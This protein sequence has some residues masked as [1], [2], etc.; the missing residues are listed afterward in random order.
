MKRISKRAVSVALIAGVMI[1]SLAAYVPAA[2]AVTTSERE[3][4]IAP[5]SALKGDIAESGADLKKV[6]NLKT[7]SYASDKITVSWTASSG[8][9]GYNVYYKSLDTAG[10]KLALLTSTKSNYVTLNNITAASKWEF[11]ICGYT[12][13]KGQVLEGETAVYKTASKPDTVSSM[14]LT[15]SSKNISFKWNGV[16]KADGYLLYREDKNT[17]GKWVE[18][19]RLSLGTTSFTDTNTTPGRFYNYLIQAYVESGSELVAGGYATLLTFDGL[20][21]PGND[22]TETLLS[23]VHLCWNE[24]PYAVG[25]EVQISPDNKSFSLLER[26]SK[27]CAHTGRLWKNQTYFFRIIPYTYTNGKRVYGTYT[28][29]SVKIDPT[30]RGDYVGN[31]YVEICIEDQYMWFYKNT[32]LIQGTPVVTGNY[33]TM[34]TPKG[35]HSVNNK[36]SPCTLSGDGY[37]SYVDYWIAFIGSGYGIHDASWRNEG[38]FGGEI[39]KGNGS[40]GCV[41]TP[42]D[43]VERIYNNI[44]IGTPV[45]VY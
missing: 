20:C 22:G 6:T 32:N 33:G 38:E 13:E 39:Y 5:V 21:A 26:T 11:Q 27:T 42:Y 9:M 7:T 8:A 17:G 36:A 35:Y 12:I 16:S 28:P 45:I 43:A 29:M 3:A 31:T 34:D 2:G 18:Y 19:K 37:T 41:N 1:A 30:F 44:S 25:Y 40:H 4:R 14:W 23:K 24:N 10:A 15:A